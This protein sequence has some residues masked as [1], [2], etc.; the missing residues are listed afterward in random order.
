MCFV[1]RHVSDLARLRAVGF[2]A[3]SNSMRFDSRVPL[4]GLVQ[5]SG[6]LLKQVSVITRHGTEQIVD[7]VSLQADTTGSLAQE[8][9]V[10]L[11]A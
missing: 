2:L 4:L 1:E 10:G 7:L 5:P 11:T 9:S 8:E 3:Q 6:D